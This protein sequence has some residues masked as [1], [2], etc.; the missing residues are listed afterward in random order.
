VISKVHPS[1][2]RSF[3]QWP[4]KIQSRARRAYRRFQSDP[5]HPGLQF[6]QL[7]TKYALWSVRISDD[8]R[9]VGVRRDD[10]IIW[11]FIGSH[12]E[13]ERLLSNYS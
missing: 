12:A 2:R 11:F 6:K 3:L 1:F 7:S 8:Y 5:A 10:E 4:K 13:Y 9:A